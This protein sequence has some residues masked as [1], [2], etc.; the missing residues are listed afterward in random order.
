MTRGL[1]FT[2]EGPE[3]AGKSTQIKKFREK[4]ESFGY[5]IVQPRE[6]GSTPT[7]ELIREILK[8]RKS[9]EALS[10]YCE[11]LLFESARAQLTD[12]VIRPALERGEYV[13]CD[14]FFDSTTAYQGYGRGINVSDIINLNRIATQGISP[15]LTFLLDLEISEGMKRIRARAPEQ[16]GK[17]DTFEALEVQFHENVRRGYLEIAT[18]NPS[19]VKVI[20]ANQDSNEVAADIW[21]EYLLKYK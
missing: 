14:R 8:H 19:R 5:Q 1:F 9:G 17:K 2:F 10:P 20:N 11:L 3:G 18:Q 6:P 4:L 15:D 12:N 21:R 13:L 16:E 7:G